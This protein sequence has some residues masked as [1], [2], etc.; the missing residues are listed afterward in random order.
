MTIQHHEDE[1]NPIQDLL[2][3]PTRS[4]NKKLSDQ[5]VPEE[6]NTLF[7]LTYKE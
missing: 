6:Q 3:L 1:T 5:P 4:F 7:F 2:S